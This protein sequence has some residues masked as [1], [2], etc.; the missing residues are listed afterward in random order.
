MS[1]GNL[2]TNSA[3]GRA[4]EFNG[5]LWTSDPIH[6][7]IMVSD[8]DEW[9]WHC[10]AEYPLELI[11]KAS[12]PSFVA[13]ETVRLLETRLFQ[14]T[15]DESRLVIANIKLWNRLFKMKLILIVTLVLL[16]LALL[17]GFANAQETMP[18]G[19]PEPEPIV[20]IIAPPPTPIT[21]P[22]V[23]I[24]TPANNIYLPLA[25]GD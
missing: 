13:V 14:A 25:I 18:T 22:E 1:L 5:V 19:S 12:V 4:Y 11:A 2:Y 3:L 8:P 9:H 20:T 21:T 10:L 15:I 16:A 17:F 24:I 7:W 23:I 6:K